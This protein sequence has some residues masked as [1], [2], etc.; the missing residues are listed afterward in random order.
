MKAFV[1]IVLA[2]VMIAI[3]A[4]AIAQPAD[5]TERAATAQVGFL[6]VPF[7]INYT[8]AAI[9]LTAAYQRPLIDKRGP[10][11]DS[12][13]ITVGLRQVYGF[14]NNSLGG[15]VEITP[16]AVLKMRVLASYD[17]L[18][19]NPLDGGVR[20]LTAMGQQLFA[21]DRIER[22]DPNAVDWVDGRD[23]TDI[24]RDPV[25]GSGL[26]L[27]VQPSLQAKLGPIAMQYTFMADFN[28]YSAAS[29]ADD[30][31]FHDTFTYT[32]RKLHD[33]SYTHEA[34]I[35]YTRPQRPDQFLPGEFLAGLRGS[36]F[37]VSGTDLDRSGLVAV[38]L[39]RPK[40]AF[41]GDNW[42]PW[43]AGHVGTL[44]S[45]PMHEGDIDALLALGID[46]RLF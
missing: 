46:L 31:I 29:F 13:N 22:G 14:V 23:N 42:Q 11:W 9:G 18:I 32:L 40:L 24:F 12:T 19:V 2:V 10:L 41:F 30:D 21:D 36:Y 39:Y 5:D 7:G 6:M 28:Y 1:V 45:D 33:R 8:R 4:P 43:L 15:F 34:L 17:H 16:I 44:L 35:A 37:S 26:R 38:L 3:N 27:Q 20:V 25:A